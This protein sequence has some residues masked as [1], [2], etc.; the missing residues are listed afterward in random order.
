MTLDK[1]QQNKTN[2]NT[3]E[4]IL[5]QNEPNFNAKKLNDLDKMIWS[6]QSKLLF[7]GKH[8]DNA[9]KQFL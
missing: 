5:K 9:S 6:K 8:R 4:Q 1:I 7:K 2:L 3:V